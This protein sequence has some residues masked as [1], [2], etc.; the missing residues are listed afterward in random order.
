MDFKWLALLSFVVESPMFHKVLSLLNDL[1]KNLLSKFIKPSVLVSVSTLLSVP[2]H[3]ISNWK[4]DSQIMVGS[5][6]REVVEEQLT[7]S[8]Q[9]VFFTNVLRFSSSVTDKSKH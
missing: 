6:A 1:L 5:Q 9:K 4:D 2:F 3:E 7:T 8:P